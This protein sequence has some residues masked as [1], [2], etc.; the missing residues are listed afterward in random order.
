MRN[1][2]QISMHAGAVCT[3]IDFCSAAAISGFDTDNQH[4]TV[5][6]QQDYISRVMIDRE[7]IVKVFVQKVGKKLGFAQVLM[8]DALTQEIVVSASHT[9]AIVQES[10]KI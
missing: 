5:K 3:L 7:Y 10:Y 9:V 4:I 8:M 1:L 2:Y 6:L